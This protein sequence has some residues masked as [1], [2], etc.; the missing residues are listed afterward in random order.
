MLEY[1]ANLWGMR[2]EELDAGIRMRSGESLAE[3]IEKLVDSPDWYE[4]QFRS[5]VDA[6]LVSGNFMLIIVVDEIDDELARIVQFI[7]A[8]GNPS[9]EF[10]ALEMRRFQAENSEMLV[11]RVFGPARSTKTNPNVVA[12]K[13]WD[14]ATFFEEII[15]RNGEDAGKDAR[16]ILDWSSWNGQ[17]SWGRGSSSGSFVPYTDHNAMRNKLMAAYTYGSVEVYF[18]SMSHKL[19]FDG[20]EKRIELLNKLNQVPGVN[21]PIYAISR[22]PSVK[23]SE[24][25][26]NTGTE[27][28]LSVFDWV[29]QEIK[30][31]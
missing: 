2:Y 27:Q 5:N 23:P 24:L 26:E 7:N 14:E 1:G 12:G 17:I 9:F 16:Q 31:S 21:I 29:I 30:S 20:E 22:R 18:Y 8:W 4:E 19:P 10:A 13:L 3:Q 11:P 25:G 6:A 28:F 15:Q